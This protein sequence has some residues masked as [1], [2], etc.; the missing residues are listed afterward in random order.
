MNLKNRD[1]A[2]GKSSRTEPHFDFNLYKTETSQ[3]NK[4]KSSCFGHF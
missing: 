4:L 2:S 1:Q 3:K